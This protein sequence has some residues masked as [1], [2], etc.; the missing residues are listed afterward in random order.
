M[1]TD[2]GQPEAGPSRESIPMT[3]LMLPYL[4]TSH[5]SNHIC[6]GI[7]NIVDNFDV[8][9]E[10]DFRNYDNVG[11]IKGGLCETRC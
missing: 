3:P 4:K 9:D 7:P 6:N 1:Q 2:F 11:G 8:D 10:M 5:D